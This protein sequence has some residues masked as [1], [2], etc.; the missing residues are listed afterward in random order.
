MRSW[1]ML[2]APAVWMLAAP[3]LTLP[4]LPMEQQTISNIVAFVLLILSLSFHEY[5][6][7]WT[8]DKLG[9]RTARDLGR[10]TLNPIPHIHL[11]FN[12]A[13]P[14]YFL[15]VNPNSGFFFGAAK[16]VPV[17]ASNLRSPVRDMMITSVAGPA[18]NVVLA[19]FFTAAYWFHVRVRGIGPFELSTLMI[20][21]GIQLNLV[22]AVFN[23][24]PI[25]PLDGHRVASFF[26][27]A[28]LRRAYES[29]GIFGFLLLI[30]LTSMRD[31]PFARL[32]NQNG[33]IFGAVSDVWQYLMPD[34][35]TI[36]GT[37]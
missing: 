28:N 14:A 5:G 1:Q 21:Q 19:L 10:L 9:D 16:P 25:P 29:I 20:M 36:F 11:I 23:M 2:M 34:R 37:R 6:H 18:M 3:L 4:R 30:Y 15:F 22:L 33:P 26:M 17:V 32:L 27:P 12:L 8:A 7:A 31:G 13:L 35:T 24:I